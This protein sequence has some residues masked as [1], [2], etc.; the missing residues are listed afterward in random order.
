MMGGGGGKCMA[1]ANDASLL[2]LVPLIAINTL[3]IIYELVLG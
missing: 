1:T 3:I 2:L